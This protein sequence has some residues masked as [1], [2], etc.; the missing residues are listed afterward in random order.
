M[1]R[2]LKLVFKPK[3][4]IMR[5]PCVLNL[6]I[7]NNHMKTRITL[8]ALLF[9]VCT[10]TGFSQT[11]LFD[12]EDGAV[13]S[14]FSWT[15][16][17][18]SS[19][20]AGTNP[21]VGGIN[22]SAKSLNVTLKTAMNWSVSFIKFALP[23]ATTI[24]ASNRY[25]HILYRT[26]NVS[27]GNSLSTLDLNL[28]GNTG[29]AGTTRFDFTIYTANE[30]HDLVVDLNGLG[31][32]QLSYFSITPNICWASSTAAV[33]VSFDEVVMT[34][35]PTPRDFTGVLGT[36]EDASSTP[37]SSSTGGVATAV[38]ANNTDKTGLNTTN[39]ALKITT[40]SATS[41]QWWY[42]TTISNTAFTVSNQ[43]RYLHCM[44][45]ATTMSQIEFD[46]FAGG[47]E[48]Y[49]GAKTGLT[50]GWKE[51]VF[52]LFSFNGNNLQGLPIT[53]IR[54]I[55]GF[56][57][58]KEVWIDEIV[59]NND[60]SARGNNNICDFETGYT[61]NISGTPSTFSDANNLVT[62]P[63][64]NPFTSGLN[65]S[66]TCGKRSVTGTNVVWYAG[67]DFN[68][69]KSIT[70]DTYHK[71]LH[72][73]MTVPVATQ[74][75]KLSVKQGATQ[76]TG[77]SD[78]QYTISAANTWQDVVVDVSSL[79]Y[80]DGLAIKCGLGNSSTATG[81]YYF[82]NVYVDGNPAPRST[83]PVL[84]TSTTN[85]YNHSYIY[86]SGPSQVLNFSVGGSG[87]TANISL[88]PT[89]PYEIS[90]SSS[91]GFTTGALTLTKAADNT[92]SS[93]I[94][95]R[96]VSGLG[97]GTQDNKAVSI[98]STS[99]TAKSVALWGWVNSAPL[100]VSG[101]S[102]SGK[103]YDGLAGTATLAGTAVYTGM[104][105]GES[106]VI[107]SQPT[108]TYPSAGVGS[109]TLTISTVA[110]PSANYS[111]TQPT[112]TANITAAPLTIT[113]ISA[114]DKV[115]DGTTNAT[116]SGAA[117]YSGLVNAESFTVSGTPSASFATATVA[118]TKA[119][120]ISGYTVP[121]SNYSITQPS[122]TANIT[123]AP[124]T[125]TGISVN[126][127]VY[128]GT[129]NA[130]LS[131]TAA[132]SGLASV[133][134]GAAVL[135]TA[136]ASFAT[137]AVENTKAVT[138]S[139]Y[140]VP[141][142]NYSITQPTGL[143]ANIYPVVS[144]FATIGSS[145]WSTATEWTYAPMAATDLVIASGELIVD[146][147]QIPNP[148]VNS[149]TINPGAKLT[150]NSGKTLTTGTFTLQSSVD[151]TAT[152]VD[153]TVNGG[154]VVTGTTS[155]EQYLT[156]GRNWYISSPLSAAQSGVF[157]AV[158][159]S[160]NKLYWYDETNGSSATLNWPQIANNTSSLA[161]MRGYVAN[162]PLDGKVTFTGGVL[163]TGNISTGANSVPAL[164]RTAGQSKEG[165]NLVGN[166]YP[167]Y[168]DWMAAIDPANTGTSNLM[169][170]MWYRTQ[171]PGQPT[172][173][174][175]VPPYYV[176]DTYN[177]TANTG[178]NNNGIA[179]TQYI[180]PMQA[181]W[182]RVKPAI[183]LGSTTG[184]LALT[185]AM[186]SH[187]SGTNRLKVRSA[188]NTAQQLLR[189]QV[190]NGTSSDEAIVLFNP[191]AS[192]GF[193][194]FDS[195]KMSN[196]NS[197]IPEI[198][199]LAGTEQVVINGMKEMTPNLELPLGFSTGQSNSFSIKASEISNLSSD[200]RVVLKDKLLNTEQELS[201]GTPYSFTSGVTNTSSRFS[202]LFKSVSVINA[203]SNVAETSSY[204]FRNQNNQIIVNYSGR[205]SDDASIAVYNVMGEKQIAMKM[206]N[207]STLINQE[208]PSGVYLVTITN[209]GTKA[210]KRVIIN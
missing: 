141:S 9:L 126:N 80:F 34:N 129:T 15:A 210:T 204:V 151:G 115:Y 189:L 198:Y 87:L 38:V 19:F 187:A 107:A 123:A 205:L 160:T 178:T 86:G 54:I 167:S 79:S 179:V 108:A 155:V 103:V 36:F 45:N 190:S 48:K 18:Y 196:G 139:G 3:T 109:K 134:N 71:Y 194:D 57:G 60:P 63:V 156:T 97:A 95:C 101:L 32:T 181:F 99:A 83:T 51:Y 25:L 166:P 31:A 165:F 176:F 100:T 76:V 94:Y 104:K 53:W 125:I 164:T 206:I 93:V 173:N 209:S 117:A 68:F 26:D 35:S 174:P 169:T 172:G 202:I 145:N 197:A 142:T 27:Q 2:A 122:A 21:S 175:V 106:S 149:I 201:T 29:V 207:S 47:V 65:T 46:L 20:A 118:N 90:T 131:G 88:T 135:G 14:G 147:D 12:F 163:N 62:V 89:S 130:S 170:T 188:V 11:T 43:F 191:A 28:L 162:M 119:V 120:T 168:L 113:G 81:D 44:V 6:K 5:V 150:L 146:Q 136:S 96:L 24:T 17:S 154:L 52:D 40:S 74:I 41:G 50:P 195:P 30:W 203:T 180:P 138:I 77:L 42:G 186:R 75:I 177:E 98:T 127:K 73:M 157:G 10:F 116:L 64:A 143:T 59:V 84:A 171:N 69:V 185:N 23:T 33:N 124:L 192:N 112:V 85:V 153:K 183:D 148:T 128:D 1:K 16:A 200:T 22:T 67:Y 111:I 49:S 37:A 91:S 55:T 4:M 152:F 39:K 66:A 121:S 132:Y 92:A 110:V 161:V 7:K 61:A 56:P 208:L 199:S 140:L 72:V 159:P 58:V 158:A 105:N 13:P 182:V 82:D 114:V 8:S 137:T 144:T 102:C 184:T 70:V 78:L 193:D 133:D